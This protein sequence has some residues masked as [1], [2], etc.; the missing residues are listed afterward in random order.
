MACLHDR[1]GTRRVTL[2]R[3]VLIGPECTGKTSLAADLAAHFGVPWSREHAREYVERHGQVLS[4]RDVDAIARGQ[5]AG[6][7]AAVARATAERARLVILDTDL[8]STMVYS[9][10]YYGDCPPWV[11]R[12]AQRRRGGLYLLHHTDVAW[13]ADG[14]QREQP[15]RRQEL[16]AL[17]KATLERLDVP[18]AEI[19]GS[20]PERRQRALV[21]IE[22]ALARSR[23]VLRD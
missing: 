15:E 3:V 21:A 17:F 7:D 12:E 1:A 4:Y 5:L 16:F 6:E 23:P 9:R 13:V 14:L 11:E 20:W 8:V 2:L 10:H 18:S 22:D 19:H